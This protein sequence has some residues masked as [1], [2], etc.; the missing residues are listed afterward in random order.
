[1]SG[2]TSIDFGTPFA[3]T[4]G[5]TAKGTTQATALPLHRTKSVFATVAAGSGAVLPSAYS[6]GTE[7]T[8][9][10]RGANTLLIYPPLGDQIEGYGVNAAVSVAVGGMANFY[11]LDPPLS[12]SPRTWWLT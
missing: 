10:N 4:S 3:G 12:A 5:L 11:S 1:M 2:S 7:L 8:V 6:A 9:L